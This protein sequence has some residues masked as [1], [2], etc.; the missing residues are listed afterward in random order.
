VSLKQSVV[1]RKQVVVIVMVI[2]LARLFAHISK[3]VQCTCWF[4]GD[5][6][7]ITLCIDGALWSL[8]KLLLS[9]VMFPWTH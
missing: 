4:G 9:A 3:L 7:F 5:S 1:V 6:D 2:T 8:M